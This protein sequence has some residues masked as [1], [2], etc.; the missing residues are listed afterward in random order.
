MSKGQVDGDVTGG[1][2]SGDRLLP[3]AECQSYHVGAG[4]HLLWRD[5][6]A[7]TD[8]SASNGPAR[9]WAWEKWEPLM[10]FWFVSQAKIIGN[11]AECLAAGHAGGNAG[12][13]LR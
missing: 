8:G 6:Q 11:L 5:Q 13:R 2:R 3:S 7:T 4:N 10:V 12:C 9:L 1:G